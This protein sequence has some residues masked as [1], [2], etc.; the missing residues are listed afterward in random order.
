MSSEEWHR[1]VGL[2]TGIRCNHSTNIECLYCVGRYSYV[3]VPMEFLYSLDPAG[4]KD[5]T[6]NLTQ[7]L[8]KTR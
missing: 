5:Y 1:M 8:A 7:L 6:S 4:R 3:S 2:R